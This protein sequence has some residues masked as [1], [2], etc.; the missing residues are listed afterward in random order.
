M[1]N[2]FLRAFSKSVSLEFLLRKYRNM[3]TYNLLT[4][5]AAIMDVWTFKI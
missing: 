3:Q 2:K 5:Q 1:R 4:N